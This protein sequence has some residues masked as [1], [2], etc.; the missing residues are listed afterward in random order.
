MEHL[1]EGRHVLIVGGGFAGVACARKLA[2]R[3]GTRVTL[4]DR[5]NYHQ[6][7]PLLYQVATAQLASSDVAYPLRSIARNHHGFEVRLGDVVAVDP[8]AHSVTTSTGETYTADVLVIA[9]GSQANFFGTPGAAEHAFPLY[10][11]DHALRLR[12]RI[13]A[14]FEEAYRDPSALDEGALDFVVVGGGPTGVETAGA[15]AELVRGTAAAEF[16]GLDI[17]RA[18]VRLVD[19][20]PALLGPFVPKAH[21]YAARKLTDKGV[22]LHLRTGVS[23]VGPGHVLLSDGTRLPTRCVIWGGG[24][25]AAPVAA[26]AGLPTGKGGRIEVEAD[27]TVRGFPGVYGIGDVANIPK[28]DGHPYPQ[29]GSVAMQSGEWVA[30]SILGAWDGKPAEPFSCRDKGIMAMIGRGAAVMQVGTE[31]PHELQGTVAFTAWLGVHAALMS[32][33]RNRID[34]FVDWGWDY[35]GSRRGP[36]ILDRTDEARIDWG[37]DPEVEPD[38]PAGTGGTL[39]G[40]GETPAG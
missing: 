5:V 22:E 30:R 8:V 40:S 35:F 23:E 38:R 20:G 15:L 13:I 18:R 37:D 14:L 19:H 7:Q 9:A 26:V 33:V 16:P 17:E 10:S 2:G 24:I 39:Q 32:G 21:E 11:L 25:A 29:L 28:P 3:N 34:A 12:S 31:H 1:V 27:F 6:F 36:Q 4:V